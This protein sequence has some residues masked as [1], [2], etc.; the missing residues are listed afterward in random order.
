VELAHQ[1]TLATLVLVP[2]QL[3]NQAYFM[4][5]FFFLISELGAMGPEAIVKGRR[6]KGLLILSE[7]WDL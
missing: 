3:I 7:R 6:V 5:F 2:F 4:G 1:D